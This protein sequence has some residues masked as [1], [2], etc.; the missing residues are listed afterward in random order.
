MY[1]PERQNKLLLTGGVG[2]VP[3]TA[4]MYQPA[5]GTTPPDILI[6]PT[7][8]YIS[9]GSN[10]FFLFDE[11]HLCWSGLI[12]MTAYDIPPAIDMAPADIFILSRNL[13]QGI[14]GLQVDSSPHHKVPTLFLMSVS[15]AIC[16]DGVSLKL[17]PKLEMIHTYLLLGSCSNDR[18]DGTLSHCLTVII[19]RTANLNVTAII[20][21]FPFNF[22]E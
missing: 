22:I 5:R 11:Q 14:D 18:Q 1:Q 8:C 3:T 21:N 7:S 19:A 17:C 10:D 13:P 16:Y 12:P 6:D 20:C 15:H 2:L 4:T 9:K